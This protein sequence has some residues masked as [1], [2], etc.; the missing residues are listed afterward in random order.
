[1]T[2]LEMQA[3]AVAAKLTMVRYRNAL[4][5]IKARARDSGDPYIARLAAVALREPLDRDGA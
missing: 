3:L 2:P 1:M 4:Q 5:A